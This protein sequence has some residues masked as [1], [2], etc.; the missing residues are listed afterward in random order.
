MSESVSSDTLLQRYHLLTVLE[1][2]NSAG[3]DEKSHLLG[4]MDA[5]LAEGLDP[6]FLYESGQ[7]PAG[8][9]IQSKAHES[10]QLLGLDSLV[11]AGANPMLLDRPLVEEVKLGNWA[12]QTI[13]SLEQHGFKVRD[14]DGNNLLHLAVSTPEG[15]EQ[16]KQAFEFYFERSP[17]G[18][19]PLTTHK[20]LQQ[21][22]THRRHTDGYSPLVAMYCHVDEVPPD[23]IR[24]MKNIARLTHF[25]V[26]SGANLQ[27]TDARGISVAEKFIA[28]VGGHQEHFE[29][30]PG[31]LALIPQAHAIAQQKQLQ[32]QTHAAHGYHPWK[33]L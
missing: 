18:A 4:S 19:P 24:T 1:G 30:H 21:I 12:I 13:A 22:A 15:R 23:R 32:R 8:M 6:Q 26:E 31:V 10:I 28:L 29:R 27:E 25:M 16:T 9:L 5:L 17:S 33:R 3:K 7:S 20:G 2:L 14:D 11:R